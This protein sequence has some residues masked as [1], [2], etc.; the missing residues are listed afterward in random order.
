MFIIH[1]LM[2]F[3][4]K[5]LC[6]EME[7]C[8]FVYMPFI[9]NFRWKGFT[10]CWLNSIHQNVGQKSRWRFDLERTWVTLWPVPAISCVC[11]QAGPV[12][13]PY[14]EPWVG[15]EDQENKWWSPPWLAP[16]CLPRPW[17][18]SFWGQA[19]DTCCSHLPLSVLTALCWAQ[20]Y[21]PVP[22][23]FCLWPTNATLP[24]Q[25]PTHTVPSRWALVRP[26][27]GF[28]SLLSFNSQPWLSTVL[29]LPCHM[30]DLLVSR[31]PPARR[32]KK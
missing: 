13:K 8:N 18:A 6:F 16:V 22:T 12:R 3:E 28:L 5:W 32:R 2:L 25:K 26:G 21:L 23:C 17:G 19:R 14:L 29:W 10:S 24:V 7:S 31:I 27:L 30:L 9:S 11:F 1:M 20:G 15:E 4:H